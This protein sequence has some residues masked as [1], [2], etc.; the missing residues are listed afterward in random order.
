M[1]ESGHEADGAVAAHAEVAD[2]VEE[3]DRGGAGGVGGGKEEGADDD[4][5]AAGF[6]DDGGAEG[7]V[8]IAEGLETVGEGAGA[9]IRSAGDDDACGF[10]GGVGVDD[11]DMSRATHNHSRSQ[12]RQGV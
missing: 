10:A 5:G 12:M 6:V 9:Q 11:L 1:A 2:V 3:D 4:I 8:V 7:V